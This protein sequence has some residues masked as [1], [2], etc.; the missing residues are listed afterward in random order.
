M[1]AA[2]IGIL[3][4]EKHYLPTKLP[5]EIYGEVANIVYSRLECLSKKIKEKKSLSQ[6]LKQ[7]IND[8]LFYYGENVRKGI[9][10]NSAPSELIEIKWPESGYR[11]EPLSL[12]IGDGNSLSEIAEI[13]KSRQLI[14]KN[15]IKIRYDESA[16]LEEDII[17]E[18]ILHSLKNRRDC[19]KGLIH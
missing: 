2:S 5:D 10:E 19:F 15:I 7:N 13:I 17:N 4:N 6:F 3:G 1:P 9:A 16:K 8:F 12:N 14:K 18:E 11:L